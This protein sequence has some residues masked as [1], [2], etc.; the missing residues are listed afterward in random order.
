[1]DNVVQLLMILMGKNLAVANVHV[2]L[3]GWVRR[4]T[5][6]SN[7]AA[8]MVP[9]ASK[10][11]FESSS[12]SVK[13]YFFGGVHASTAGAATLSGSICTF[14]KP[15]SKATPQRLSLLNV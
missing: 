3:S 15:K 8:L 2:Q 7:V 11:M 10:M 14:G 4:S 13:V 9:S 1:M 6:F 12:G 5:N